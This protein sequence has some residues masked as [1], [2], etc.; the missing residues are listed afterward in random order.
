MTV[1]ASDFSWVDYNGQ[2]HHLELGVECGRWVTVCSKWNVADGILTRT[3][4]T[5]EP[6]QTCLE[7]AIEMELALGR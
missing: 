6:C 4:E 2:R 7:A 1:K 5:L 3:P